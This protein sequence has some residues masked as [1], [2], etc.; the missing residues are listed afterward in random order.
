VTVSSAWDAINIENIHAQLAG[1]LA[2]RQAIRLRNARNATRPLAADPTS[3]QPSQPAVAQAES[4]SRA[5][6][7]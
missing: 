4:Q 1:W 7:I 6:M 2:G 5:F 3:G